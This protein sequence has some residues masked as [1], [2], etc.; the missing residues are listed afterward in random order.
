M[1]K[2]RKPQRR[3]IQQARMA[4][5]AR[6]L[7]KS[8]RPRRVPKLRRPRV[9]R[10]AFCV[11]LKGSAGNKTIIADR[12][13][14]TVGTVNRLLGREDWTRI[15]ERFEQEIDS[16]GDLAESTIIST[17]KS[18]EPGVATL[19]ARW[20]L[21]RKF[22]KRGFGNSSHHVVEGGD[23][24]IKIAQLQIP[25]ETLKLSLDMRKEILEALEIEEVIDVE[26]EVVS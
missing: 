18:G 22:K 10:N 26:A 13:G 6:A 21:D 25:I 15:R 8:Q 2:N 11:A 24:A 3:H 12:L 7:I 14:I 17:I 16:V 4:R 5:Q 23:R 9:S 20:L 19:N 1:S